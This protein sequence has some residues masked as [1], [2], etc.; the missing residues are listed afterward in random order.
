MHGNASSQQS[1]SPPI[2]R[3]HRRPRPARLACRRRDGAGNAPRRLPLQ[4]GP[5]RR[6]TRRRLSPR[7]GLTRQAPAPQP[8]PFAGAGSTGHESE[9]SGSSDAEPPADTE[10]DTRPNPQ[11]QPSTDPSAYSRRTSPDARTAFNAGPRTRTGAYAQPNSG[12]LL[13]LLGRLDRQAANRRATPLGH[14]RGEQIRGNGGQEALDPQLL[15]PL[16]QLPDL[17][18]R[19][20]LLQLPGQRDER[21]PRARRDSL[22]Q[23]GLAVDP[24]DPNRA[25]LPALRRD[26]AAPTT[27]TSANSPQPHAIGGTPS[28]SASTGR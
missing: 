28:S 4:A 12:R 3:C 22:L 2:P 15:R 10:P 5:Q 16:R 20:Q 26:L 1:P 13:D 21:D 7:L 6:E 24:L 18:R 11:T 27:P 14:G 23:L 19:L 9:P 17:G 25:Q 8:S